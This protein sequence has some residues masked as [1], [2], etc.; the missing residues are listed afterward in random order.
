M[1]RN[2]SCILGLGALA[3]IVFEETLKAF[4]DMSQLRLSFMSKES[5]YPLFLAVSCRNNSTHK[6]WIYY[7]NRICR[8]SHHT[9]YNKSKN[10]FFFCIHWQW[11]F[12]CTLGLFVVFYF[13][14]YVFSFSASLLAH[15]RLSA[16]LLCCSP[17]YRERQNVTQQRDVLNI[18]YWGVI[19]L[20][21]YNT[22]FNIIHHWMKT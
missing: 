7:S 3:L 13:F 22:Q 1:N 15:W 21:F 9:I 19:I 11:S 14:F 12:S 5:K 2:L 6:K 10:V 18:N 4:A 20:N 8:I 17:E 16:P